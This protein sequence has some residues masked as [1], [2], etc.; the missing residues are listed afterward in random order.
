MTDRFSAL[1]LLRDAVGD[2]SI[3]FREGQWEAID[4]VANR[5][6]RLLLVQ[7]TGWGKSQV[8]FIATRI[9]RDRGRGPT[10]IVSPL[11]A[12]MRN[13]IGAAE[14][15]G[16]RAESINSANT[17]EWPAIHKRL[18]GNIADV[19]LV[20]PERLANDKFIQQILMPIAG[21]IGMLVVDEAHCISDW[22][23]DFRP[24]YR[25]LLHIL[26]FMPPNVPILATTATANDRVIKDVQ[27][28]L[29]N[30]ETQRGSL[31]RKS[32][33]LQTARKPLAASVR[34]AW[35][36][37]VLKKIPGTGIVYTL[38]RRDADKVALWLREN[39][40]KALAYYS[41]VE[42]EDLE[43]SNEYRQRL[44]ELLLS[45]ELKALVAT[46][47]LGMGYDKPDLG[48]VIHYQA[49]GSIVAYYQQ[50]GRA[51]RGL[52]HAVGVMLTGDEDAEIQ[53]YFRRSAFPDEQWIH[54][55]L[56]VLNAYDGLTVREL[57]SHVNLSQSQ[58]DKALKYLAVENPSPVLKDESKW[59]RTPV[60][61]EMDI[62]KI[63]RLTNQREVEWSEVQSYIEEPG[64]LMEYLATVLDD[65]E[66]QACGK[67]SACTGKPIVESFFSQEMEI[68]AARF[69]GNSEQI[70]N[71]R[72]RFP[73]DAF[74]VYD[75]G[76]SLSKG[77]QARSGVVFSQFGAGWGRTVA[78]E[79]LI[80]HFSDQLVCA[81]A[82]M[83]KERWEPEPKPV[84]VTCVPSRN[85]PD[86]IPS[87][88]QR[89]AVQLDIPF[90]QVVM[91]ARDN[92]Q[93]K[94]QNNLFHQCRNLDGAFEVQSS[95]PDGPL[96]LVD[97]IVDSRLTLTIVA[98]L[99]L[100]NGSGPVFPLALASSQPG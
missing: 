54:E 41:N 26:Q 3:E 30:L 8:Y 70:L 97:D 80:G 29:G 58:L 53:E 71:L 83:I 79:K 59:R 93:Q 16:V 36:V 50:V 31:M 88:A 39:G 66:P 23:H 27:E 64:C 78:N 52:D 95:L 46:P 81:A 91:K 10:L 44:E 82:E 9:L 62:G 48:F 12:L 4:A 86:L 94:L 40:I 32:L 11:L 57:E 1:R 60:R 85:H 55:I 92:Q 72:K 19:L 67:C 47:A 87:F 33:A 96:L 51:G 77:L 20:S 75:F 65:P 49:P 42:S 89:L 7:R 69:L 63:R 61:Y 76:T 6:K 14:R 74:S 21:T 5:Q 73:K 38:T 35:L 37:E 68:K 84:W 99:L 15:I 28:Q 43:N 45:N 56:E 25:R 98:A 17:K 22:G 2:Q 100:Q 24:D 18:H 34:L 90:L 13:Q